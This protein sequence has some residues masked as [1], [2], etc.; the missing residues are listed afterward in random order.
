MKDDDNIHKTAVQSLAGKRKM[1]PETHNNTGLHEPVGLPGAPIRPPLSIALNNPQE[2]ATE[3]PT[4]AGTPS[5][6]SNAVV[7]DSDMVSASHDL[8]VDVQSRKRKQQ[9]APETH[10]HLGLPEQGRL[11]GE[12]LRPPSSI[13]S[14]KRK[15]IT[16]ETH[17]H[18]G[19]DV[20]GGV[21]GESLRPPS[22]ISSEGVFMSVDVQ[23]PKRKRE[24]VPET[25][26]SPDLHVPGGLP[27]VPAQP[28]S[29][30]TLDK[31]QDEISPET[32]H[33]VGIDDPDGVPG[34]P[35]R[36]PSS[37][38]L[39]KFGY[40]EANMKDDDNFHNTAVQPVASKQKMSSETHYNSG[41]HEPGDF[42]G[43]P[44]RP[45]LSIALNNSQEMSTE[46]PTVAG[47]DDQINVPQ[48]PIQPL[49]SIA[50]TVAAAV[51]S[52]ILVGCASSCRESSGTNAIGCEDR[53]ASAK[54]RLSADAAE[55]RRD[56]GVDRG[57]GDPA[58]SRKQGDDGDAKDKPFGYNSKEKLRLEVEK[59]KE[60]A[61]SAATSAPPPPA[62]C[63]RDCHRCNS[64]VDL[65]CSSC[66][67]TCHN[68]CTSSLC[69]FTP[70]S[71]CLSLGKQTY[72]DS[73]VCMRLQQTKGCHRCG[74][75]GCWS[76][77]ESC[78]SR[79][80]G[81][82][83]PYHG[84][85]PSAFH[86]IIRQRPGG[87]SCWINSAL[88]A[89]LSPLCFKEALSKLWVKLSKADREDLYRHTSP[90]GIENVRQD[91]SLRYFHQDRLAA[92]LCYAHTAKRTEPFHPYLF[93]DWF[94]KDVQN[95]AAEFISRVL[96]PEHVPALSALLRGRMDQSLTCTNLE[97]QHRRLSEGEPF[98]SL[99]LPLQNE[100]GVLLH[101]VQDAVA[102]YMPDEMVHLDERC[103]RCA[104]ASCAAASDF[105]FWKTHS[106]TEFPRVLV[107]SL[108]RWAGFRQ[109]DALLH[110][111]EVSTTL[112]FKGCQ[113]GLCACV[114]HLGDSPHGGH[115]VAVARHVTSHGEWWLYDD[116]RRV[117]AKDEQVSTMCSYRGWGSM[118]SYILV[119][120]R[121]PGSGAAVGNS[122][123]RS[124]GV[125]S[126]SA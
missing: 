8:S 100:H 32:L 45:P 29:S 92:T 50:A 117:I 57:I 85:K 107:I 101:T 6:S 118:Q 103:S 55:K 9:M 33:R 7:E 40:A 86:N 22:S 69:N 60:D 113:Y 26:Q 115:Y 63:T 116:D 34:A 80:H 53:G 49:A 104:A 30:K 71:F 10:T 93:T 70:C 84:E 15:K 124:E 98:T 47:T 75:P 13:A 97:C 41:F 109:E 112:N 44:I 82:E 121:D 65:G 58:R 68:D 21:A 62:L 94:Y 31:E 96:F 73:P 119:Y 126:S 72:A 54:S 39:E 89:L 5:V 17:A 111:I 42:P 1:S 66:S 36:P 27:G 77:S 122:W 4:A 25:P 102:A 95:D 52:A 48:V 16:P 87:G 125:A 24:L 81:L 3:T 37:N 83:I 99:Q 12:S 67:W 59:R 114:S 120:E 28:P 2:M 64:D 108:N 91:V 88:Q 46:T 14:N 79:R 35:L 76:S 106:V 43:A 56:E 38:S 20:Q 61:R 90:R 51:G 78:P 18:A 23:S 19:V 110:P 74:T 105:N 11:P 123:V